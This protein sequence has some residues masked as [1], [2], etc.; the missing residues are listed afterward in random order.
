MCNYVNIIKRDDKMKNLLID[1]G[2]RKMIMNGIFVRFTMKME[3]C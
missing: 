3:K 1:K 2:K